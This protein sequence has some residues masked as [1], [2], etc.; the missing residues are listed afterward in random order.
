MHSLAHFEEAKLIPA[1]TPALKQ[2]AA[3]YALAI[4]DEMR[5]ISHHEAISMQFVPTPSELIE[6]KDE[7]SDPIGDDTHSPLKGLVHRYPD[8]VLIKIT[9]LCPVYCRFC[10]RR[11]QVG[12]KN[13][14][15]L[16]QEQLAAIYSYITAN[17]DIYEVIFTGGDPL[18]L[19]ARRLS[20]IMQQLALISHVKIIRFHTRVPIVIPQ[21]ITPSLLKALKVQ[22]KTTYLAVHSNSHHEWGAAQ[23]KAINK[24][25]DSGIPLLGQT[26]LLKGINNSS[27][28]LKKLFQTMIENRVQPYYL[29]HPDKARGTSHFRVTIKE[30]QA[31]MKELRGRIS[32]FALPTYILDIP[33]GAGKIPLTPSYI[34][35]EDK[36]SYELLDPH[37]NSHAYDEAI[38]EQ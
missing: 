34:A 6:T 18:I 21:K 12:N 9:T 14:A 23:A 29:H 33:Q 27:E 24:L 22:G 10:F 30:G 2:V 13:D 28:A 5:D 26:V 8:R 32:G 25:A 38:E 19:S 7:L 1:I 31:I 3:R 35:S 17:P 36:T 4:T 16:S 37:G 11:E 15:T 20:D